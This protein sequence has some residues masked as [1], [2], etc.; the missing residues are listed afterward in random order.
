MILVEHELSL[1]ELHEKYKQHWCI[2][3]G[4]DVADVD[5][6]VGINGECYAC[7]G[8]FEKNEFQDEKYMIWL[9]AT[10]DFKSDVY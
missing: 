8:E 7:L 2:S 6:E 1:H 4:Y 5:E 9:L 3:R 10:T